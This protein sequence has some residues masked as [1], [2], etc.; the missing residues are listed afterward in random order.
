MG[1]RTKV[2]IVAVMGMAFFFGLLF[3][4]VDS[5]FEFK[6]FH[7]NLSFLLLDGPE[8]FVESLVLK[9]PLHSLFVRLSFLVAA[10]IGGGLT[11]MFLVNKARS[12]EALRVSEGKFRNLFDNAEV[13]MFR[14]RLDGCEILDANRKFLSL[15]GKTREETIGH[16]SEGLWEDAQ[17]RQRLADIL[18]VDS[19]V[20]EFP[21]KMRHSEKG[22]R[23]CTTSLRLY[24]GEGILEG[25]IMD[26]TDRRKG[27][28]E[29]ARLQ[30]QL[31]QAQKM[32]S[33]GQLAG[34][35]AH[36]FNNML[37]V[38]LGH[39]EM[40]MGKVSPDQPVFA[41]L[42]AIRKAGERSADITRQ[43][44]AF[45]R[46]QTIAPKVIDLNETIEKLLKMLR[47][48]IGEDIDLA[49]LP[50]FA[51]WEVKA[52]PVQIDQMLTNICVNARAAIAGVGRITV[53]TGNVVLEDAHAALRREGVSGEY[54]RIAISDTGRGMDKLTLAHIF[55]PF[56][57]TK[58][59]GEGTGLGLA[60]VYGA[61]KQNNGLID[62]ISEPGKGTTF[63]IYLPRHRAP[64]Q[65]VMTTQSVVPVPVVGG[66]EIILLV[67]DEPAILLMTKELLELLG[68]TV[69]AAA[70]PQEALRLATT[71]E[72]EIQLLLTDIVMP[73]MNGRE[74]AQKL[75]AIYPQLKCLYMSGY[76]SDIIAQQGIL[77]EGVDFIQKPFAK[78][79]L[80]SKIRILFDNK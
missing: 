39:A 73:E 70:T 35:V 72:S 33:V 48:L 76:T 12:D 2:E 38:I 46:R 40:A 25:S 10:L 34:G 79:E 56:F 36:D 51:L 23:D 3:W 64:P 21:F 1:P 49:W 74:L 67:E 19:S 75:L 57:T 41:D 43:L 28:E 60:T 50:G 15:I 68:Y 55:E 71:S 42:A 31:I 58:K 16:S 59:V 78:N 4:V 54:V 18:K 69:R 63:T 45:A 24:R 37:G 53:E 14:A 29:R 6:F 47:R 44:L 22:V 20:A 32:E 26:I 80:A 62:V 61:V 5:Y 11:A 66:R 30:G 13:A 17:E 9:V 65:M 27:E 77:D 52:D 8:S 7:Q